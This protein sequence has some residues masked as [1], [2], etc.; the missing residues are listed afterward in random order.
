MLYLIIKRTELITIIISNKNQDLTWKY[1]LMTGQRVTM[2]QFQLIRYYFL[3]SMRHWG[4]L[5]ILK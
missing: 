5:V 1:S 3:V 2:V 4:I